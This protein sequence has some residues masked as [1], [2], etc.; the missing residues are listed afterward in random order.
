M[1]SSWP[2]GPAGGQV[3]G[4]DMLVVVGGDELCEIARGRVCELSGV[5]S[6]RGAQSA[7]EGVPGGRARALRLAP[8]R[9]RRS[10]MGSGRQRS[11]AVPP[12]TYQPHHTTRR[13]CRRRHRRSWSQPEAQHARHRSPAGTNRQYRGCRHPRWEARQPGRFP[14]R[15]GL[16]PIAGVGVR[17]FDR[18]QNAVAADLS[19]RLGSPCRMWV[20][21]S[22]ASR[23]ARHRS[24]RIAAAGRA[25]N[26][27]HEL[28]RRAELPRCAAH[29]VQRV[30]FPTWKSRPPLRHS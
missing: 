20:S 29:P 6:G 4:L 2:G 22:A 30:S 15:A 8:D 12:N 14:T 25:F 27:E 3:L 11:A 28:R 1:L 21:A 17:A 7:A 5:I 26:F 18:L 16:L 13:R 24:R 9:R 10:C 23:A 19:C